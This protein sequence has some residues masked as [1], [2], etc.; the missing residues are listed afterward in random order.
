MSD[1]RAPVK[2]MMFTIQ[3]LAGLCYQLTLPLTGQG[4][5]ILE[6]DLRPLQLNLFFG[7][8]F[9]WAALSLFC[10]ARWR[11]IVLISWTHR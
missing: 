4:T 1:Y 9:Y 5:V 6:R 11:H 2:D 10:S 7:T 3:H 8:L